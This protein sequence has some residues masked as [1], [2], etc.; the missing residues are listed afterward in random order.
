MISREFESAIAS[1]NLLRARVMLK[2]SLVI[3]PTFRQLDEMLAYVKCKLPSIIVSFDGE[4]L[5]NDLAG[6][7]REVMNLELVQLVNNFSQERVNHLKQIISQVMAED[8]EKHNTARTVKE[9]KSNNTQY[10]A[11]QNQKSI[12]NKASHITK[13]IFNDRMV[14]K[15]NPK[16]KV[17][18][19]IR[20]EVEKLYKIFH[21]VKEQGSH[22]VVDIDE[23]EQ[24]TKQILREIEVYKHNR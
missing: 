12:M 14:H 11:T 1:N 15:M 19:Q 13:T 24:I 17:E 10:S 6:R 3:D 20:R 9:S 22:K 18:E 2:D 21:Q 4:P 16:K 23:I 8:I 5:Q 7:E